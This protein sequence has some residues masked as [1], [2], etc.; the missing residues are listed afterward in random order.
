MKNPPV[1]KNSGNRLTPF[2][3]GRRSFLG[4]LATLGAGVAG[5][6]ILP[7]SVMAQ[8][9]TGASPNTEL[10]TGGCGRGVVIASD[11]ATVAETTAGKIRGFKRNGIYIFKGVPYGASTA[12]ASIFGHPR[13]TPP[14]NAR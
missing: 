13:S 6:V 1:Q 10:V 12:C 3:E 7:K 14:I 11:A 4:G 8:P 2:A 9:A 5:S